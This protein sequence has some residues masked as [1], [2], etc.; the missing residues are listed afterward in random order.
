M[1]DLRSFRGCATAIVTPMNAD[2]S[3]DEDS[4][5]KL[6]HWQIQEGIDGIVPVGTTGE[7]TTLSHKEHNRIIEICIKEVNSRVP[8]FAGAGS[9]STAEACEFSKF[10]EKSGADALLIV[11]PYY[12]KPNQDGLYHHFS[13][14][15][16]SVGIPIIIYNIPGR[17]VV[18][19]SIETVCKLAEAHSNIIGIKDVDLPSMHRV[20]ATR[21]MLGDSFLQLSGED[22]TIA[23][24]LAQGGHG[25]I[26]VA[27]NIEPKI[28]SLFVSSWF[29]G[30]LDT[31]KECRDALHPLSKALFLNPSP[32][33]TKYALSKKGITST[34]SLRSPLLLCDDKTINSVDKAMEV[35]LAYYKKAFLTQNIS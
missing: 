24:F 8:V 5:I 4:L 27:S 11:T 33:P 35:S 7:S 18:N 19:I 1:T 21:L 31:F 22:A 15:A 34:P 29:K 2:G 25:T 26:S 20:T 3:I 12:N 14:I 13:E 16:K 6:I 9:N 23:G 30:D 10:A 28:N 17:S 32:A